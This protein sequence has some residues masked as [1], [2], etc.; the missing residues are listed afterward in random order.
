MAVGGVSS[1]AL[2]LI[3]ALFSPLSSLAETGAHADSTRRAQPRPRGVHGRLSPGG[4]VRLTP[5]LVSAA[6]LPR[7]SEEV[8]ALR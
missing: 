1:L 5:F 7:E 6:L 3:L 8:F 4:G 2:A